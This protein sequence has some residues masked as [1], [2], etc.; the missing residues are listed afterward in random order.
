MILTIWY[1]ITQKLS[2]SNLSGP[3]GIFTV[4][5]DTA[6]EGI[7]N[8]V[9][10]TAYISLN[11]GF[12]NLLPIPALDGGRLFFLIIEKI[13]GKPLN[14]KTENI[15]NTIGFGLL[16]ALILVISCKDI[17]NLFR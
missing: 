7:I 1:L 14:P 17:L 8:L 3:I 5:A 9:Y 12:M 13:K 15:I 6:K 10:L 11:L 16:M 2:I 4:V